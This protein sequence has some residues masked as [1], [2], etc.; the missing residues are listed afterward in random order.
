MLRNHSKR[1]KILIVDDQDYNNKLIEGLLERHGYLEFRSLQDSNAVLQVFK[2]WQPDLILLDLMMPNLDGYQVLAKLRP[3]IHEEDNLPIMILTADITPEAK[4]R[5]LS[6]GATDFMTKPFDA[7]EAMLRITNLLEMRSMHLK[8]R[9]QNALLEALV[10]A[11]TADLQRQLRRLKTLNAVEVAIAGNVDMGDLLRI[12]LERL[13]KELEIDAV[14]V[15]VCDGDRIH[16]RIVMSIGFDHDDQRNKLINAHKGVIGRI[17]KTHAKTQLDR[18]YPLSEEDVERAFPRG[19]NFVSYLGIPLL[20]KDEI[21]GVLEIFHRSI[22]K[23]SVEWF[24]FVETLA[25]QTAA[26]VD[27]AR[28]YEDLSFSNVELR[29]AYDATIEGWSRAMD[30]RDKETEGHTQRVTSLSL[31][32]GK[33]MG[34]DEEALTHIKRGALLHDMGK[35]GI[36]DRILHKP[37]PLDEDEWVIMKQHPK[38]AYDML[39]PVAYLRPALDIP[40]AHHEKWNGMGYP[41]GLRGE[42]IP[43]SARIFSVVDVWDALTSD[44]PYRKAWSKEK[45]LEHLWAGSG[46]DFD[47]NVVYAFAKL[48]ME[49][50]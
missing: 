41:R 32:I 13:K 3:Y 6:M 14:S 29:N 35:L 17:V 25:G 10:Q 18:T 22:L 46:K 21:K 30:L 38:F 39:Y 27:N 9:D 23:P 47:P 12:V 45:T 42:D 11:R 15:S 28:L 40:Y 33:A 49:E 31:R 43:L 34:L 19:E 5:A 2:D 24:E 20:A 7:M 4:R 37:G 8:M 48:I 16:M 44:R 50:G 1:D 36:P 26:A